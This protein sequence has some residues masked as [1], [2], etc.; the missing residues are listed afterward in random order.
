MHHWYVVHT[1]P[2]QEQVAVENLERQGYTTYCPQMI[3]ARHRRQRWIKVREPLFPRYLF[4]SLATGVDNFS[5][6][7]STTGVM[8][9]VKF[10]E[11]PAIVPQQAITAIQQQEAV[12]S[13]EDSSTPNWKAGDTVHVVDGPFA[14][15]KG[16]FKKQNTEERVIILLS[17]L[18]RE[19][20]ITIESNSVVPAI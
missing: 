13:S 7:R 17:I 3:Q 2:K 18:G 15:L 8:N 9:M 10:G 20:S 19:N 12:F 14:G 11:N 16:I 5:P 1:K 6:I 4:V